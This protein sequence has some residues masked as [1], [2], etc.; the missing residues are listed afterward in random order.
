ME[1]K[2]TLLK[3]KDRVSLGKAF[4]VITDTKVINFEYSKYDLEWIGY[5]YDNSKDWKESIKNG[6]IDLIVFEDDRELEK[7]I[8]DII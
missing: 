1:E 5:I 6:W 2:R 4:K 8:K 7:Y 3:I